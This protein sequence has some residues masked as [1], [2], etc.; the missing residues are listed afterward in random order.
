[1]GDW[2]LSLQPGEAA[3]VPSFPQDSLLTPLTRVT[4]APD[5]RCDVMLN[6]HGPAVQPPERASLWYWCEQASGDGGVHRDSPHLLMLAGEVENGAALVQYI[7]RDG[8]MR[9]W[10]RRLPAVVSALYSMLLVRTGGAGG[11]AAAHA[12]AFGQL[13]ACLAGHVDVVLWTERLPRQLF[14]GSTNRP[15]RLLHDAEGRVRVSS[16]LRD[17][18]AALPC[19]S[20]PARAGVVLHLFRPAFKLLSQV[21]DGNDYELAALR[22]PRMDVSHMECYALSHALRQLLKHRVHDGRTT[23]PPAVAAAL[24][25]GRKGLLIC[26]SGQAL[27]GCRAAQRALQVHYH[28]LHIVH[29]CEV[30]SLLALDDT[31]CLVHVAGERELALHGGLLAHAVKLYGLHKVVFA[32]DASSSAEGNDTLVPLRTAFLVPWAVTGFIQAYMAACMLVAT[33][34][35]RDSDVARRLEQ[36]PVRLACVVSAVRPH[37]TAAASAFVAHGD[38]AG[39]LIVGP[40]L[41]EHALQAVAGRLEFLTGAPATVWLRDSFTERMPL[42]RVGLQHKLALEFAVSP[43]YTSIA[44]SVGNATFHWLE[45]RA[46]RPGGEETGSSG[47]GDPDPSAAHTRCDLP[48]AADEF[49]PPAMMTAALVL[50]S[51]VCRLRGDTQYSPQVQ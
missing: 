10:D 40:R 13:L 30:G 35:P 38:A 29:P 28:P 42:Q 17:V 16:T 25:R 50:A 36:I 1:M 20:I 22:T 5:G 49:G 32:A 26:A 37:M 21:D 34:T 18:P 44:R 47:M 6:A 51:E 9:V 4:F 14:A 48:D 41:E 3:G 31:R 19:T 23:L 45:L 2:T 12:R 27:L 15:L 24:E 11:E 46:T 43:R 7:E 39:F 8:S 33:L